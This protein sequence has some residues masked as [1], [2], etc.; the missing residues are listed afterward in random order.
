MP[1][2][3]IHDLAR[4]HDLDRKAMSAVRGGTNSWLQGLGPV[5]DVKVNVNQNI[6]QLQAVQVN[7][8]NNIGVIGAGFGPLQLGVNPVQLAGT[9]AVF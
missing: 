3:I 6:E 7:A 5:A 8:L 9:G 1:A 2:I 4:S